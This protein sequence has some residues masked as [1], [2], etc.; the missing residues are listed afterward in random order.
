M[1]EADLHLHTTASDGRHSPADLV[2]LCAEQGLRVISITDHDTLAG[3][4]EAREAVLRVPGMDL[5]PGVE[6]SVDLPGTEVHLLA[7]GV[8]PEDPTLRAH[9]ERFRSGREV[10]AR[11]MVE[12]LAELGYPLDWERVR[13][14]AGDAPVGRPHI[15]LAMVEQG[16]VPDVKT[17]FDRFLHFGGPAYVAREKLTPEETVGLILRCRGVPVLAHPHYVQGLEE[18]LPRLVEA[19]LEGMEVY[20]KDCT[21][22]Q[23]EFLRREA[24]RFRLLPTG[25]TDFHGLGRPSEVPPGTIGPP[26]EVV[27]ALVER[28]RKRGGVPS[29]VA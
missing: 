11:R 9:L 12:R 23:V 4:E 6:L 18:I 28:I 19:G 1:A 15:A 25:G 10:R 26:M 8:H 3:L 16:Y 29:L 22:E 27:E 14:I 2:R 24:E 5:I 20:Y 13:A 21:P 17:A 7:Y